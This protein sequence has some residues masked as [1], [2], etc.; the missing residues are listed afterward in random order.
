MDVIVW[1]CV[2]LSLD[3]VVAESFERVVAGIVVVVVRLVGRLIVLAALVVV[4]V[5]AKVV[6]LFVAKLICGIGEEETVAF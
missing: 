1:L 3:S 2:E 4:V 5:G 6:V